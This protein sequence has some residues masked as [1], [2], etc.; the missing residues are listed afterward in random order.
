MKKEVSDAYSEGLEL[1]NVVFDPIELPTDIELLEG[2]SAKIA[3]EL[4]TLVLAPLKDNP[5]K[6]YHQGILEEKRRNFEEGVE[7]CT[8]AIFL[9]KM[10]NQ[11]TEI[12]TKSTE[13]IERIIQNTL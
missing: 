10:R 5:Q 3:D 13:C 2:V 8:D 11:I 9:E 4:V 12:T 1:A 6:H 7:R